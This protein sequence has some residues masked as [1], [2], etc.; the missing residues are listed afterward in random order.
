MNIRRR[1]RRAKYL[2][3]ALFFFAA[4]G[5]FLSQHLQKSEMQVQAASLEKFDAGKIISD[6]QMGN[7]QSMTEQQIQE[8]LT[9]KNSCKNTNKALYDEMTSLY[10]PKY[11]W[12][13]DN[14]HFVCLSEEK[15]GDGEVIGEGETAAHIIWQA[16]QDYKINPQVL[17]VLLQKEQGLIT[18]TF[19]NSIQYRSAT[20]YGCPDTAACSTKYYGFKNQVRNAASMFRTVL[21]GGWTN[22]PVGKNY[23]QYN[24]D[25]DCGGSVV[26]IK[27][28]ATSAL[29]RYT[30]YQPS[31][32][33][34]NAGY[35][36]V[37]CGAYGNRNFYLYFE[38]WFGGIVDEKAEKKT[39]D[40]SKDVK[41]SKDTKDSKDA[42]N[43]K[44]EI[45]L[46]K[47]DERFEELKKA[48]VNLGDKMETEFCYKNSKSGKDYCVQ[49]YKNGYII[50]GPNGAWESYGDI[51]TR[52]SQIKYEN[53]VLGYPAG[54]VECETKNG[55]KLCSQKYDNGYIISSPSGVWESYGATRERWAAL[56]SGDGVLGYP[57]D[58]VFCYKNS[59]N[60]KDY[61][62][63]R[64]D[65]GYIISG[66]NGAWE[67]YGATRNRWAQLKYENGVLGYPKDEVY[68]YKNSKNDKD[69]CVQRYD[70]GYIISGPNGAWESYGEIRTRWA[71]LGYENG[72]LGYPMDEVY[73][74]KNLK[75]GKDYCVQRYDN[76]YIIS[77]PNGTWES[78]GVTRDKWA[79][80]DFE[81]GSYGYPKGP[82][83]VN[84][85]VTTQQYDGGEIRVS[86]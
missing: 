80:T 30:P 31:Q 22:Y 45:K 43:T 29:Y 2:V 44:E 39:D 68:C 86:K 49:R 61:C 79:A 78:Y 23:V 71:A 83:V 13:F 27:N 5:V 85:N 1:D 25:P 32:A 63:Q 64:Y 46:S 18:D 55:K 16:A 47:T 59:K 28:K 62:V 53:G 40:T 21:N 73:C 84:G 8:F 35:G 52:W 33:A 60:G 74:Y 65:N 42:K 24:P 20:G 4:A 36:T 50:S 11:T 72:V 34:L 58:E 81:R 17:L 75:N 9:S 76:G 57:K 77:G 70:N 14:G 69:Y 38:D 67:S 66:P 12:H 7:Y 41:D 51:R 15:F 54:G 6:Y 19:P 82:V 56:K 10:S 3:I 26:D 48:G 37:E